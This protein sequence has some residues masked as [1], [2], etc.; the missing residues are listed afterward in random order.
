MTDIFFFLIQLPFFFLVVF[1]PLRIVTSMR[2]GNVLDVLVVFREIETE[3]ETRDVPK[4]NLASEL[5][6]VKL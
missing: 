3:T 6:L 2:S 5:S 4:S 1:C